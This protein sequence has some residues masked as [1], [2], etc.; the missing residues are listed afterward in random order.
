MGSLFLSAKS[1]CETKF[2]TTDVKLKNP[3][4]R[5]GIVMREPF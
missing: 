5:K 2:F 1:L 4:Q 3:R